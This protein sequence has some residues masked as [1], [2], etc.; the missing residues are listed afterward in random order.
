VVV[1]AQFSLYLN[2]PRVYNVIEPSTSTSR[3]GISRAFALLPA[4]VCSRMFSSWG[5]T[6]LLS[7]LRKNCVLVTVEPLESSSYGVML[8]PTWGSIGRLTTRSCS[9]S[10]MGN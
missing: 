1:P 8:S 6:V 7:A 3:A 9:C 10:V 5:L 4:D 2:R